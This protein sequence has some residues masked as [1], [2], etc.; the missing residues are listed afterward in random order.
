MRQT[1]EMINSK[2]SSQKQK[3]VYLSGSLTLRTQG[4]SS[5]SDTGY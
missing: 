3:A 4:R 2:L 1:L 5:N